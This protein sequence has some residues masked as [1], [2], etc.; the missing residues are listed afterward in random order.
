[1]L[2]NTLK[3]AAFFLVIAVTYFAIPYR[4]RWALLL[5]GSYYFFIV[6]GKPHYVLVILVST[7]VTYYCGMR[8][9][10]KETRSG[11]G[12]FLAIAIAVNL[13]FLFF[14]KYLNLFG[15]DL[16]SLLAH[17]NILEGSEGLGL[18]VPLGISFYTLQTLSYLV[19]VYRGDIRPERHFGYLALYVSFFPTLLAGPIERGSHLL[20]QLHGHYRFD[21]DRVTYAIKLF[22]WG[23]FLKIVI[24]DRLGLYVN[25]VYGDVHSYRGLPLLFATLFFA[26]QLYCDFAGYTNMT[27]ACA[28]IL[29]YDLLENFDKPYFAR[30]VREFW[31]RWHIS[32][33]SWLRDYLYV[34]LGGNRGP[35][36]RAYVNVLIVFLVSGLWHGASWTF[37]LWGALHGLY[38]LAYMA[39]TQL[40]AGSKEGAEE[41]HGGK[42][43]DTGKIIFTFCLVGLAWVLFRASSVSDAFDVYRNMFS[44]GWSDLS[45]LFTTWFEGYGLYLLVVLFIF[46]VG[47][48]GLRGPIIERL[49]RLP[50]YLRWPVYYVFLFT[51]L[52]FAVATGS[53]FIYMQF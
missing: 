40:A 1:M 39:F 6:G 15:I 10:E 35:R 4:F 19:D 21:Y 17:A 11:R 48:I 16:E 12:P 27:R 26:V 36:W 47:L 14:F 8:M 43:L 53:Q 32:L 25:Q 31:R 23:M 9:G 44:F 46:I 37:V 50:I 51:M 30:N 28:M 18:I 41:R 42:L 29:G 22:A 38:Y 2:L 24:A 45:N 13:G 20:P 33:T 5:A 7:A 49:G 3:F 34:P 52:I